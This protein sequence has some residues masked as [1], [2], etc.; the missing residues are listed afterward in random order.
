M[1]SASLPAG[2]KAQT[3]LP[4][5][6]DPPYNTAKQLLKLTRIKLIHGINPF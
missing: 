4:R 5:H 2:S 3:I 1:K 6:T